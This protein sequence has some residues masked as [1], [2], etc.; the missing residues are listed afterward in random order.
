SS[1]VCSSDLIFE[2]R[3]G[4][5]PDILHSIFY[6]ID[7]HLPRLRSLARNR[8]VLGPSLKLERIRLGTSKERRWNKRPSLQL[9][10]PG[11]AGAQIVGSSSSVLG[12]S[13]RLEMKR[14]RFWDRDWRHLALSSERRV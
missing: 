12:C 13:D 2:R 4:I 3:K 8:A 10:L 7:Q 11:L 1:D 14:N 9:Y 6:K 5:R